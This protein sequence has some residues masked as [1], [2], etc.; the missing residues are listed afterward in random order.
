MSKKPSNSESKTTSIM[1]GSSHKAVLA[2]SESE[3]LRNALREKL[4]KQNERT[5]ASAGNLHTILEEDPD[6]QGVFCFD[7]FKNQL[8][9]RRAPPRLPS[10]TAAPWKPEEGLTDHHVERMR[11]WIQ[12]NYGLNYSTDAIQKALDAVANDHHVHAVSNWLD[13]LRWDGVERVSTMLLDYF[14]V[15]DSLYARRCAEIFLISAVARAKEPGCKVDT[16]VILKGNQGTMKSTAIR[17]LASEEWFS[18]TPIRIEN[19]DGLI[20]MSGKWLIECSELI[21]FRRAQNEALKAFISS[22][23]DIYRPP[24][25]RNEIKVKRQ[26]IFVGATNSDEPLTDVTGARRFLVVGVAGIDIT[27]LK[28]VREQLW[29]EAVHMYN[30]NIPW[31]PDTPE[32]E[33]AAA[34]IAHGNTRVDPWEELI[35]AHLDSP[36][37]RDSLIKNGISIPEVLKDVLRIVDQHHKKVD[38]DRISGILKKRSDFVRRRPGSSLSGRQYKYFKIDDDATDVGKN[39]Q[40]IGHFPVLNSDERNDDE[41]QTAS[42]FFPSKQGESEGVTPKKRR[43]RPPRVQV[44]VL[45]LAM[46]VDEQVGQ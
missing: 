8:V 12:H 22:A 29:A 42:S 39:A 44:H 10:K 38:S 5:V 37:F 20:A 24:H 18:D 16:V 35:N 17:V 32:F 34:A 11:A 15:P 33:R 36:F 43:G 31:W 30:S 25:A 21:S 4:Q 14:G 28:S 23:I 13:S 6:C 3:R 2:P 27:G 41:T 9:V 19:K 26:C 45:N 40:N 1:G 7:D 46:P